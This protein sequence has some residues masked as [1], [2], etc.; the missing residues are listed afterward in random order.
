MEENIQTKEAL[1][2]IKKFLNVDFQVKQQMVNLMPEE[3]ELNDEEARINYVDRL[4]KG[5]IS[6]EENLK[7]A[8]L[9]LQRY[10]KVEGKVE[11]FIEQNKQRQMQKIAYTKYDRES[12]KKLYKEVIAD[13]DVEKL[14]NDI[15]EEL[16]AGTFHDLEKVVGKAST[17]N[18]LL[19]VLHSYVMNNEEIL[20]CAPIIKEKQNQRRQPIKLRGENSELA[21]KIF[22]EF[23]TN[24]DSAWTEIVSMN[25]KVIIMARDLGHALSINIEESDNKYFKIEYFIPKACNQEKAKKLPGINLRSVTGDMDGASGSFEVEKGELSYKLFSFIEQVPTDDDIP[26]IEYQP[27]VEKKI[28]ISSIIDLLKRKNTRTGNVNTAI[29]EIKEY[30]KHEKQ[31]GQER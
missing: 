5:V 9:M 31:K 25:G 10:T 26:R 28:G 24:L 22:N 13:I 3:K 1:E 7:R 4:Y 2:S 6:I 11:E 8:M 23:P 15:K 21:E 12:I 16:Y 19:H 30:E 27:P 18:E 17:I 29:G 20:T 14:E